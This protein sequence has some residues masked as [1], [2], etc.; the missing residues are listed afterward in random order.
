MTATMISGLVAVAMSL[1]LWAA[2]RARAR[3]MRKGVEF[4][5]EYRLLVKELLEH[6]MPEPLFR[7][8]VVFSHSMGSGHVTQRLFSQMFEGRLAEPINR[9]FVHASRKEW[10]GFHSQ[11][12]V[13]YVRTFFSGLRAD[14]YFAGT[15]R[16]TLF[17]RAVFYLNADPAEIAHAVDAL[18]T[19]ILLLGA[20][21]AAERLAASDP[22][23]CQ[24]PLAPA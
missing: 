8:I 16:G 20:E 4:L 21:R 18:E 24:S 6:E 22:Q 3:H 2:L 9:D 11:T 23:V 15:I 19:R 17:R 10:E 1:V 13:L 7:K 14:S 5:A 12:R